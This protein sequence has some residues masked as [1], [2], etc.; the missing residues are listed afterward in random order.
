MLNKF[1]QILLSSHVV[2]EFNLALS[3]PAFIK[4]LQTN[5]PE[6]LFCKDNK[7]N[8]P[9][10]IYDILNH[11][12]HSVEEI[13]KQTIDLD[14]DT[15]KFLAYTMFFHDIGKPE[16]KTTEVKN[17][18][19]RDRFFGHNIAS[20]K[21]TKRRIKNFGFSTDDAKIIAI[22]VRK[23]DDFMVLYDSY[24]HAK[25]NSK[26]ILK[27]LRKEITDLDKLGNGTTLM[28]YLIMVGV[29]DRKSQNPA[30]VDKGLKL[31]AECQVTLND[32]FFM[33]QQKKNI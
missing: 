3:D 26:V 6:I 15:Q 24:L 11:V 8:N 32:K 18:V 21:I 27:F 4:F 5:I 33:P 31:L 23:H 17:G 10:H 1:N 29:A 13:N 30:M 9:W 12:L 19:K 22:L 2:E 20:E 25:D 16:C 7:Q 14:K 28:S